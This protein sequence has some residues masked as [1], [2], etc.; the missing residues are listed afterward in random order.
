MTNVA[1]AD[2]PPETKTD[3]FKCDKSFGS[4]YNPFLSLQGEDLAVSV[5]TG[6]W[7]D[8]SVIGSAGMTS[9]LLVTDGDDGCVDLA[10]PPGL[11]TFMV[12]EKGFIALAI[13]GEQCFWDENGVKPTAEGFCDPGGPHTSTLEGSYTM[14]DG[15][16]DDKR[17]NGG[18]GTVLSTANHC[19]FAEDPDRDLNH[20]ANSGTT[21]FLGTIDSFDQSGN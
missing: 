3:D 8:C 16:I 21:T 5:V 13:E 11:D 12:N 15:L 1:Q 2:D 7:V 4:F 6:S 9:F 14:T 20:S 18:S 10:S 17:V 19:D